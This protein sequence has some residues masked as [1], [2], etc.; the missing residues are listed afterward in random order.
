MHEEGKEEDRVEDKKEHMMRSLLNVLVIMVLALALPVTA[1]AS[2]F[3]PADSTISISLGGINAGAVPALPGSEGMVTLSD[4]GSGH[5]IAVASSVWSTINFGAG[6]SLYTGIPLISNIKV[7]VVNNAAPSPS[8]FTSGFTHVNYVGDKSVVG[9]YLG[10]EMALSGEMILSILKG[11]F[12]VTFD[13]AL[14]GGPAGGVQSPTALGIPIRVTNAPWVTG[15]VPVTGITTNVVS[16]NGE[17]G[18]GITLRLT[19]SQHANVLSTGGGYIPGGLPMEYHT[20]TLHGENDLLSESR[21]GTV[22]LVSPMR[23]DTT[24]AISG[25][26]PGAFWMDLTFVPEPGTL[27]LLV[28]GAIGLAVVGHR[29]LRK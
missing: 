28:T 19:P 22:T 5:A 14:V 21:D 8:G 12:M 27:L 29:R 25:R 4:D 26:V 10:G 24:A 23:V 3:V 2:T 11:V 6:T 20:V 18:A 15:A 7:T 13:L 9:P 16:W 17:T 1:Q